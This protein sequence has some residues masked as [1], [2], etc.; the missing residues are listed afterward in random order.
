MLPKLHR[1]RSLRWTRL[2]ILA[3]GMLLTLAAARA[4]VRYF[5]Y[6]YEPKTLPKGAVE[7]EQWATMR[8]GHEDR[9]YTRWDLRTEFE[10]GL[11]D[12][13]TS[14]LYMNTT[15]KWDPASGLN[16]M[17]FGGL[18]SEWKLKLADPT[19]DP[20]GVLLYF[21]AGI[22]RREYEAEAKIVLGRNFG[23]L[24]VAANGIFEHE[25]K[26]G[27]DANGEPETET[28]QVYEGTGGVSYRLGAVS[29]GAEGR[30]V[31]K[32]E[33]DETSSAFFA[34]PAL[35]A[36]GEGWWATV[37]VLIQATDELQEF[38]RTETRVVLGV[39]L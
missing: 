13:L 38:E 22:D 11:T 8:N 17:Y 21:E 34:G 5:T 29:V 12:T 23:D 37:T 6:S 39:H 3:A 36:S 2:A 19:V 28:E 1:H 25:W 35:H 15:N 10:V 16:A 27:V 30:Y 33:D 32:V 26:T 24:T 14:A 18:S 20:L 7:L 9:L 4:D 31:S